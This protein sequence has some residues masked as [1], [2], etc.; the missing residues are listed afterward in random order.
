MKTTISNRA[1]SLDGGNLP[2]AGAGCEISQGWHMADAERRPQPWRPKCPGHAKM[3]STC[4][5]RMSATVS[6]ADEKGFPAALRLRE[7]FGSR[8][9]SR[10]GTLKTKQKLCRR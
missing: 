4:V 1:G 5:G 10:S 7:V 9:E 6:V 8:I 3:Q 2:R